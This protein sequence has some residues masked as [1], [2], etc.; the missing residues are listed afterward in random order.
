MFGTLVQYW[1]LKKEQDSTVVYDNEDD[2]Y[3]FK[4]LENLNLENS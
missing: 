1:P 3:A 2:V 4:L